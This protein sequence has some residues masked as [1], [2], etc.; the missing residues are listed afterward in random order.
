[1]LHLSQIFIYVYV[2]NIISGILLFRKSKETRGNSAV[3]TMVYK[4]CPPRHR[5]RCKEEDV[6]MAIDTPT[7]RV[8]YYHKV[9]DQRKFSL[10]KVI[11]TFF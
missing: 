7:N 11:M 8:L 3:M 9:S 2:Y 1:M 4:S 6:V 5:S 10:P